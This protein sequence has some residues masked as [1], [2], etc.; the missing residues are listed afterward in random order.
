M[1]PKIGKQKYHVEYL[2]VDFKAEVQQ[3]AGI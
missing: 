2:V 1:G 3:V